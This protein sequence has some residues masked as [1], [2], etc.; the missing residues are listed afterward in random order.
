MRDPIPVYVHLRRAKDLMDREYER[1]LD[2]PALAREGA[3]RPGRTSY[4]A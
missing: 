2:V 3:C 4:V 1:E